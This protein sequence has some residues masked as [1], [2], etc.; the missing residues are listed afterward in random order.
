VHEEC[1]QYARAQTL[2]RRWR[3]M[4][5]LIGRIRRS[6]S[7]AR[8]SPAIARPAACDGCG[9]AAPAGRESTTPARTP[10]MAPAARPR[11]QT[12]AEKRKQYLRFSANPGGAPPGP[13][14][15]RGW[16][17]ARAGASPG[18][19]PRLAP[20]APRPATASPRRRPAAL[21]L[22]SPR[23]RPAGTP[24]RPATAPP[25]PRRRP[26]GTPPRPARRRPAP[27]PPRPAA[28]PPAPRLAPPAAAPP[29]HRPATICQSN[30]KVVAYLG[31]T[32]RK[33][34]R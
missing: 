31:P 33:A 18:L 4:Q 11:T 13:A 30:F 15:R 7:A 20:P 26:A 3:V 9:R 23:H 21:G 25:A 16:R 2:R 28:A 14:P 1:A 32:T 29:R 8:S 17:L 34:W 6:G 22:A 24:P 12:L 27:P 19:A 10:I 5:H